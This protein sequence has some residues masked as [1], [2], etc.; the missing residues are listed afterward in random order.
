[1]DGLALTLPGG[2]ER[3]G[4]VFRDAVLT[5]LNGYL[6][7]A[8]SEEL[9]TADNLP[10]GISNVLAVALHSI[11]GVEV[12]MEMVTTLS[13]ADRQ[14]IMMRLAQMIDGDIL[15]LRGRCTHCS[16]FFDISLNRSALPVREASASYPRVKLE[17]AGHDIELRVPN[18]GDQACIADLEDKVAL[19]ALLRACF[20]HIEPE[21]MVE[22]F[23]KELAADDIERIESALET[24]SP[25][26]CTN[27]VTHCPECNTQQTLYFDPYGIEVLETEV[28]Y[29]QIHT[30]A[31]YYHWSESEIL[32][33]PRSRR[34]RYLH[35]IDTTRGVYN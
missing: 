25:A 11:G 23:I 18:G 13:V 14:Y 17:C 7:R 31:Y 20:I 9:E 8:I 4:T 2:V 26:V 19:H 28:L 35:Y 12:D 6:E 3:N 16:A 24:T 27:I 5:P 33:L 32:K 30:L 15:W 22:N 10:K 1:M 21:V 34:H 29:S